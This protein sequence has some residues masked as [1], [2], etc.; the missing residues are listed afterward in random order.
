MTED[1]EFAVGLC[2]PALDRDVLLEEPPQVLVIDPE[3]PGISPLRL[4]HEVRQVAPKTGL[5]A[6]CSRPR[7]DLSQLLQSRGVAQIVSYWAP[8]SVLLNSIRAAAAERPVGEPILKSQLREAGDELTSREHEVLGLLAGAF[9]NKTIAIM[10]GISEGTVKRHTNNLYRKLR[11][12][13]RIQ[14]L[15]EG[16]RLGY[17]A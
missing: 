16:R 5:V 3:L 9:S 13:S 1:G 8:Q 15:L 17:V 14:A 2:S 12:T 10:L 11:V 6:L 7:A 4:L